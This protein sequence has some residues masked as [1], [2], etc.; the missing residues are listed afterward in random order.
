MSKNY[1]N[2]SA[3]MRVLFVVLFWIVFYVTQLVL[4]A[5]VVAQCAFTVFTG[6]ANNHLLK[7]GDMLAKYVQDILRY[8][9][10]NTDER[11][12]P[13]NEFPQS[14]LVIPQADVQ[15]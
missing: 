15:S 14:D 8:V 13:F 2:K 5:V 6:N 10:F 12:F 7:F 9:T 1:E 3:W 11:P 4:A